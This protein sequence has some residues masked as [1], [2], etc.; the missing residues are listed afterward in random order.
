MPAVGMCCCTTL[1]RFV[2][3][4]IPHVHHVGGM[5]HDM[6]WEPVRPSNWR[7]E[8]DVSTTSVFPNVADYSSRPA[9]RA[10]FCVMCLHLGMSCGEYRGMAAWAYN[11]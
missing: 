2:V 6:G 11:T 5:N 4:P 8:V 1:R 7:L 3:V 9:C 10:L